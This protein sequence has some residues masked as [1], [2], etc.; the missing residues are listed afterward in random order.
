MAATQTTEQWDAAWT[1]TMRAKRKRLTDN[2]SDS[3]PTIDAMRKKGRMEIETGGKEIQE[4]LMYGLNT[5]E[6]FDGYD[7]LN[8]DAVDGITA[9]FYQ[10][11]Y[12]AT[13]ITISMTEEMENRKADRAQKLLTSKTSQSMTTSFDTINAALHTASTGKAIV[14]LPDIAD[15]ASGTT[16]G[17]I[18]SG[19]ETWW[20]N[21]RLDFGTTYTG[22]FDAVTGTLYNATSAMGA[23]WNQVSE[24]NDKPDLLI[25]TH[26][27]Y[28]KYESIFEG[29]GHYRFESTKGSPGLNGDNPTFRGA[30]I[31]PDRDC[32][33]D[34]LYMLQTKYLKLK[35]MSGL[36]F[37]KTP[38]KEPANQQAKV[39][40]V[41]VGL[42]LTTNNRRRQGVLYNIVA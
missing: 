26:N 36:N 28:G 3:Y 18:D 20:E 17:G 37:A 2:I 31:I 23:L 39:A 35:V 41:L 27:E 14:G 1:H 10:F 29:T 5:S 12:N 7:I 21:E 30:S 24:G 34:T 6:W 11:R 15:D 4:D 16:V 19:S 9:A 33:A 42:Q 32:A 40:F 22:D 8:T 13:P 38:F 25:T